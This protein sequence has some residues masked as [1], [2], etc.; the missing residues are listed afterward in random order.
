[1]Y[2]DIVSKIR[3]E[4]GDSKLDPFVRDAALLVA[5]SF[6]FQSRN[7]DFLAKVCGMD[8]KRSRSICSNFRKK[9]LWTKEGINFRW[10]DVE[11]KK[12]LLSFTSA[13]LFDEK[14]S[15]K[16]ESSAKE[17]MEKLRVEAG[18]LVSPKRISSPR[19]S[20]PNV[21]LVRPPAPPIPTGVKSLQSL[22]TLHSFINKSISRHSFDPPRWVVIRRL[23]QEE[24]SDIQNLIKDL[25]LLCVMRNV[26]SDNMISMDIMLP[27]SAPGLAPT[28]VFALHPDALPLGLVS[29]DVNKEKAW[30]MAWDVFSPLAFS[31]ENLQIASFCGIRQSTH[32][33]AY[34]YRY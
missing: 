20:A 21:A 33:S 12:G 19:R 14:Y 24:W 10:E 6:V 7:A 25:G 13:V 26:R 34:R 2:E 30:D 1:M 29:K 3:E 8:R 16:K 23:T 22:R 18:A 27:S 5:A 9:A 17:K 32:K 15:G 28:G 31:E 4:I 11:E